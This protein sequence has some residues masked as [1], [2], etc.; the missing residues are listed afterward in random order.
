MIRNAIFIHVPRT[1][2]NTV[3]MM[4]RDHIHYYSHD[5]AQQVR[6]RLGYKWDDAWS[7]S[8]VRNPWERMISLYYFFRQSRDE[9]MHADLDWQREDFHT[10][11]HA[12]YMSKKGYE[13]TTKQCPVNMLLD[14]GGKQMV[15][16]VFRFEDLRG[17]HDKIALALGIEP[18]VLRHRKASEFKNHTVRELIIEP[19]DR[20]LIAKNGAWEIKKFG[21]T[22]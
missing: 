22:F 2:G 17:S 15:D 7:F 20:E 14:L 9:E 18:M 8:F 12:P 5:T 3:K 11:L 4:Y 19:D 10:W 6:T 16:H 13:W 1:N 21:Y